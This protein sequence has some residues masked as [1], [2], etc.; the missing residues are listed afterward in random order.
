MLNETI[1]L[2]LFI[3][4]LAW[5]PGPGNMFF[6]A[7]SARF[8]VRKTIPANL[9]YHVA[10]FSVMI[11]MGLGFSYVAHPVF[12]NIIKYAGSAYVLFLAYK[13]AKSDPKA[14]KHSSHISFFDGA[15]LLLLNPKAYLIF[16]L[17]FAQFLAPTQANATARAFWIASVFTANNLFSFIVWSLVGEHISNLL[18]REKNARYINY[19]FALILTLVAVW[20]LLG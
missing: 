10:T 12:L 9:G 17:I 20:I 19:F 6:V 8:G 1:A 13:L 4:P 5:S 2:L 15:I 14:Q 3:F 16:G 7:N 18:L 11:F